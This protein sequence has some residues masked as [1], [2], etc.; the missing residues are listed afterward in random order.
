[1]K[2]HLSSFFRFFTLLTCA[3][4]AF[5][6]SAHA[7]DFT[8]D[9]G[10][11]NWNATNWNGGTASGPVTA[12]NTATIN[13]GN[14][15]ANVGGPGNVDSITLGSGA[16]LNLYNGDGGIYA[17]GYFPNLV[18]QG[19]TVNGGSATYHAYG[20][21]IFGNVTV[22][23]SAASTI[24]GASWFNMNP[25]TTF[26]V[27]DATSNS[28]SDLLVTTSLRALPNSGNDWAYGVAKLIKEGAGT[29][30]VTQHSY[31]R[32]G[33]DLNA[34]TL[35]LSGGNSGYGFFDGTVNVNSGTTLSISS[36]GTGLGW[37]SGWKPAAVNIVGGTIT[38]AGTSHVWGI[39]GGVNMTG[40]ALQSNNGVSDSNGPQLEWNQTSVT[41][42]A[43]ADTASIGGRIRIRSDGGYAGIAFNVD[44]GAA[45]TDLLVSAAVT[46]A[47]GGRSITKSGAGTMELSGAN[48][49]T[50]ATT[51]NAGTLVLS[52]SSSSSGSVAVNATGTLALSAPILDD[53]AS[54]VIANGAA[55]ALNFTG[56]D[57][58]GSLDIDGSGPLP[59]GS[60]NSTTHPGLLSGTGS[61]VILGAN[62]TWTSLA[63]GNWSGAANWAS[64]AVAT[65]YDAT[66]TFN[67]ATGATVTLDTNRI[68]GKLAFDVSDYIL[69]GT[70]T[71][72]LQGAS[73]PTIS[74][75]AGRS[76]TLSNNLGGNQGLEK[77]GSGSLVL[78]GVKS[79]TGGTTVTGGTLELSSTSFDQAA[80]NGSVTVNSGATLKLTGYEFSGLG[81]VGSTVSYLAVDGG[82]VNNTINSFVSGASVDLTAATLGGGTYH[83]INSGFNA[84]SSA[85]ASTISSNLLIRVD[86]G[87]S[88]LNLFIDDGAAATDLLITGNIG[89]V[90][91]AGVNKNGPGKLVLSGTNTYSGNTVVNDGELEVTSTLRFYPTA[92][93]TNN[94]VSSSG[95]GSLTFTGTVELDLSA[96]NT[97]NGNLWNLFNLGS[98]AVAP[99][100]S[101][102]GGVSSTTL[103]AFNEVSSGTWELPVTNAK[104]VF[105]EA[106]GN[107]AYV[108]TASD[109]DNWASANGV[110]GGGNDDSDSDGL[111][112]HE[113]YAFGL[114]P[115]G[116]SSVNAIAVA[117][118]KTTGTFSYTRRTQSLTGLAYSV[119]YSTDLST[120]AKDTG[121]VE[122]T[123]V[124]TGEVETVP[125][126]LGG[127]LL[128]NS[129]LFIQVRAE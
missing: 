18:L 47:S 57:T 53:A 62:G 16:Q 24:T 71:L 4:I 68:I 92:N 37:Q 100:L 39:S 99:S 27:A 34:G 73:T 41:T 48:S 28:D 55:M 83:V 86:Y 109:Y 117:L 40:G 33:L 10:T 15:T 51:V 63:D 56:S 114:D 104:W 25:I 11:G 125:V 70:N 76:A 19:G 60:Y 50:G 124:V 36:D 116:A 44:D 64:S 52:G 22:S 61:L 113:E 29:M 74:V 88:N 93:G 6:G 31:F 21:S 123:P 82:T 97:T 59:A 96:A 77:T 58:V 79:Y 43:S 127:A 119:W 85:T 95:A 107:L 45:A 46:E 126:T 80:I 67:A 32:G 8:W 128:S 87:S 23:G 106:D 122:G 121:A 1:M 69:A 89:S 49:Y 110:T 108:V 84:L 12:G 90:F 26:A 102:I 35:K 66:A 65:G 105:T 91:S 2:S 112:N 81:R 13:S 42:N 17:Y 103:G 120:W 118:D 72:T 101:G 9:G 20:A 5:A 78:S 115:T 7:A 54:V 3:S 98:F 75:G 30:E 111:T 38:T 129:K 94:F 14:V